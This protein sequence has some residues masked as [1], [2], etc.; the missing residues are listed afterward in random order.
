MESNL[1]DIALY[2]VDADLQAHLLQS[3]ETSTPDDLRHE[4]AL[5]WDHGV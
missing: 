5:V 3:I 4:R 2:I 1:I